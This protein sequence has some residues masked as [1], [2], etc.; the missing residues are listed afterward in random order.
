LVDGR[1]ALSFPPAPVKIVCVGGGRSECLF[2]FREPSAELPSYVS[3]SDFAYF[4]LSGQ[5]VGIDDVLGYHNGAEPMRY[6]TLS[7]VLLAIHLYRALHYTGAGVILL[8]F[9]SEWSHKV[10]RAEYVSELAQH[11]ESVPKILVNA[12]QAYT[13]TRTHTN[14]HAHTRTNTHA[15]KHIHTPTHTRTHTR[16]HARTHA[17]TRTHLHTRTHMHPHAHIRTRTHTR[18]LSRFYVDADTSV[19]S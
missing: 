7:L 17:L 1:G 3:P 16:K 19:P 11:A 8:F 12:G 5:C 14:A 9:N 4:S 10:V 6:E 13:H 2:R 18:S 15:R